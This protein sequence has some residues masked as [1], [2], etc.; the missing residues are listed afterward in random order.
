M[1]WNVVAENLEEAA[2]MLI[3]PFKNGYPGVCPR[4]RWMLPVAHTLEAELG[5]EGF[6]RKL[7]EVSAVWETKWR[8][9]LG[10]TRGLSFCKACGRDRPVRARAQA[11]TGA[12]VCFSSISFTLLCFQGEGRKPLRTEQLSEIH[13]KPTRAKRWGGHF[14]GDNEDGKRYQKTYFGILGPRSYRFWWVIYILVV[15]KELEPTVLRKAIVLQGKFIRMSLI[16]CNI[17]YIKLYAQFWGT[18]IVYSINKHGPWN[19]T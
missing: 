9:S 5:G 6:P 12:T 17:I 19:N 2:R 16:W 1:N 11:W 3:S 15:L 14:T 18:D 10:R 8:A 4:R 13:K 7:G